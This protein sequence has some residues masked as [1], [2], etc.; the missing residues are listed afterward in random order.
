[1]DSMN[2]DRPSGVAKSVSF[3]QKMGRLGL[4][5]GLGETKWLPRGM[6]EHC[7]KRITATTDENAPWRTRKKENA[8]SSKQGQ[9]D[10]V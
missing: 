5:A 2:N 8:M 3:E 7:S 6:K 4:Q 10:L 9:V 1:M